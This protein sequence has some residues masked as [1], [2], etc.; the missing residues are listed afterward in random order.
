MRIL[1]VEDDTGLS[2]Q[3]QRH[4]TRAGYVVDLAPDGLEGQFL[5]TE[6]TYDLA[7]VDLGLP[8]ID[9][10]TLISS[11]RERQIAMPVLILTAR[12][13]WRDKVGGLE[14]GA[15]DY[16]TK[17]F[18]MEELMARVNALIRRSAGHATPLL[19]LG[20]L[21]IN[22]ASQEVLLAKAPLQLTSF[23][24]KLLT[25]LL[26]GQERVISKAELTEHLYAQD[27]DRDSNV[28]EVLIGRL[29]RKMTPHNLIQTARGQGY[30]VVYDAVTE[31]SKDSR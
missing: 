8:K 3:L 23:E 22:T 10:V 6:F 21:T 16:L 2:A 26:Y 7:V 13:H 5:A 17:P 15:D 30:R 24:Y 25:Y 28:I 12:S 9:G 19:T 31:P 20:P 4:L 18:Q 11:L 1:V 27:Y 29:R 14:A